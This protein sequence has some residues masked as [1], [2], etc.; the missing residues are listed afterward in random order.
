[1]TDLEN[2][3]TADGFVCPKCGMRTREYSASLNGPTGCPSCRSVCDPSGFAVLQ[4]GRLAELV[5]QMDWYRRCLEDVQDRKPVR[6]LGEAK[7]GYDR[8]RD[9][10]L[11]YGD[12]A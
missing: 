6:G 9:E 8:A 10:L 12:V 1:M 7:A 2:S 5:D 3:V 4:R 11:R